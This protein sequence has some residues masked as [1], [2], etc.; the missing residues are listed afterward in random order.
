MVELENVLPLTFVLLSEDLRLLGESVVV[1]LVKR[2]R[3]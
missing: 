1:S 2:P 3:S